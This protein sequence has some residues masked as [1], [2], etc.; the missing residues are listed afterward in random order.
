MFKQKQHWTELAKS[1]RKL[2]D[3]DL[4]SYS[5]SMLLKSPAFALCWLLVSSVEFNRCC[6]K[7]SRLGWSVDWWNMRSLVQVVGLY[8]VKTSSNPMIRDD[9]GFWFGG[10]LSPL[11]MPRWYLS[12]IWL[13]IFG[14][15]EWI[16]IIASS[17]LKT[18]CL[19][20]ISGMAE[21]VLTSVFTILQCKE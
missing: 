18:S 14:K 7:C 11:G 12:V 15:I 3:A 2:E 6:N 16:Y 13:I 8:F 21:T 17:C 1:T 9:R 19:M 20:I 10:I 4:N 5:C